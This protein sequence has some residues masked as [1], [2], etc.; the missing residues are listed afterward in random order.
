[1]TNSAPKTSIRDPTFFIKDLNDDN[2]LTVTS[3]APVS[4]HDEPTYFIDSNDDTSPYLLRPEVKH[5]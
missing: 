1:M 5:V 2:D 3:S 4:P